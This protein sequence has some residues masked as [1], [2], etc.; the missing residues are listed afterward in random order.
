MTSDFTRRR[1]LAA[2]GAGV[3]YFALTGCDLR[4]RV[5][6]ARTP[7]GGSPE[8]TRVWPAQNGSSAASGRAWDF[9]SRPDLRPPAVEVSTKK[10]GRAAGYVFIAPKLGEGEHG[11][12][13]F[14]EAGTPVWFRDG[15]YALNFRVQEYRGEPVL[16]W[17]EGK[18][19][20]RPSVGEYVILDGSY[21]EVQRVQAG[22]GYGGNQH[23]F[24]ITPQG[25]ALL[26]IYNLVSQ[27]LSYLGGPVAGR[28]IEGVAQEPDIE[29]GE[30]L[31]EW[32]S[33]DHVGVEESYN[34]NYYSDQLDYFHINSI[35]VDHD[36]N[37]LISARN[38]SAVYKVDKV[39]RGSGEILWRLGGK[40]SDFEMGE[41]TRTAFQHDARRQEDG[42]ITIFDNGAYPPVHEQSRAIQLRL[43]EEAMKATLVREYTS[44]EKILATSQGNAQFLSNGNVLVGWGSE[45]FVSEFSGDGELLMN[46]GFPPECESYRAFRFS[47]S[48][49]P[50]SVAA[51]AVGRR[52][53]NRVTLYASWNGSTEVTAWEVLSG[54]HPNHLEPLGE[55]PRDGFET[56]MLAQTK[57]PFVAVRARDSSG[58]ILG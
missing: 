44:P 57:D 52:S 6:E 47:W 45:P 33:L 32:H 36:H 49:L 13:I 51:L 42:T 11:P 25:T 29:T 54:P 1:F 8:A 16:T 23:D 22:N 9:R 19:T 34:E 7:K 43:D 30:V 31:F 17:W 12:M 39:E 50:A 35:D 28:V 41:G 53:S 55:V 10:R 24:L 14:D 48:G 38:T 18:A 46:A 4:E 40:R 37:L 26:T 21:R 58:E 20:P 3:T 56:A 2:M 27:D 5:R 15:L